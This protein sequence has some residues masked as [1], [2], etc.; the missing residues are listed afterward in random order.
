MRTRFENPDSSII[1]RADKQFRDILAKFPAGHPEL[2]KMETASEDYKLLFQFNIVLRDVVDEFIKT[3][4]DKNLP[5]E[6]KEYNEMKGLHGWNNFSDKNAK[7]V[8]EGIIVLGSLAVTFA[9][10]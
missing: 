10:M 2:I 9:T 4:G 5:V 7:L 6:L 1:S 3:H 8:K